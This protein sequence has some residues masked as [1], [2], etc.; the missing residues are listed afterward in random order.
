[1]LQSF[2][3]VSGHLLQFAHFCVGDDAAGED[4]DG[5]VASGWLSVGGLDYITTCMVILRIWVVSCKA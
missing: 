1:M 2:S 4:A 5:D 3:G